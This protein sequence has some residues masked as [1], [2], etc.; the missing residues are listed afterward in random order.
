[1]LGDRDQSETQHL[2]AVA[3]DLRGGPDNG[4]DCPRIHGRLHRF[5]RGRDGDDATIQLH[6]A[7]ESTVDDVACRWRRAR[8][9]RP[10]SAGLRL[11]PD[12]GPPNDE[13]CR[14]HAGDEPSP[15]PARRGGGCYGAIVPTTTWSD[16]GGCSRVPR[17]RDAT[18]NRLHAH[19]AS[20]R[21]REIPE[22]AQ[23]SW[24]T[25]NWVGPG[26]CA[27][28]PTVFGAAAVGSVRR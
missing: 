6:G 18:V 22:H 17:R 10:R 7:R 27:I 28:A 21:S 1:M 2:L 5:R 15:G 25:V 24:W 23:R 20:A 14:Q 16:H 19:G 3:G 8:G 11:G 13:G 9:A 4:R 26:T 12:D